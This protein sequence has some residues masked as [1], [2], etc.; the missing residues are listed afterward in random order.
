MVNCLDAV[1]PLPGAFRAMILNV[2][3]PDCV[4]VPEITPVVSFR[5]NPGGRVPVLLQVIGA[6]PVA[7]SL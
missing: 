7:A 1:P 5:L 6:V 2:N 3:V 4:G